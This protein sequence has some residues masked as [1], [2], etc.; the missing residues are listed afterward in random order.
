M[1][2]TAETSIVVVGP[3]AVENVRLADA[4]RGAAGLQQVFRFLDTR[5][6][7]TFL[8]ERAESPTAV[9]LDLFVYDPDHVTAV[10]GDM[11]HGFPEVVSAPAAHLV[12]SEGMGGM[13]DD[14]PHA[15]SG[16]TPECATLLAGLR[17]TLT[18]PTT[19]KV[20]GYQVRCPYCN[21]Y[22]DLEESWLGTVQLCPQEGCGKP[23][24][25]NPFKV[26]PGNT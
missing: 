1:Q 12:D 8:A 9:F 25:V 21:Q 16:A 20:A 15:E 13:A 26:P 7:L 6:L 23:L 11:R 2:A 22:S 5:H 19:P 4:L 17:D 14:S 10:I 18:T 3:E 24:K